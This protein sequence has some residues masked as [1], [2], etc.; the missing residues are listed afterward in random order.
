MPPLPRIR[1]EALSQLAEGFRGRGR[2]V[3]LEHIGRAEALAGEV[4]ARLEYPA[5]WVIFRITGER[6]EMDAPALVSGASLLS[7]LSAIVERLCEAAGL[8]DH[9]VAEET[10]GADELAQRWNIS[11]K[12]IDRWRRQGLVARRV[13]DAQN[14][15]HV[16]FSRMASEAFAARRPDL[17]DRAGGF[18]RID[19]GTRGEMLRRAA[20]YHDAL[21]CSLS[22]SA[23]RLARRF[24]RSHEAIR[25]L[26]MR[27]EAERVL[28]GEARIFDDPPPLSDRAQRAIERGW[29]RG[30]EPAVLMKRYRRSRAGIH[31]IVGEQR[32]RRLRALDLGRITPE[33]ATL[34]ERALEEVL[35]APPVLAL[36]PASAPRDTRELV[37]FMRIRVVP[38]AVEERARAR[39][40]QALRA[41]ALR[42]VGEL[43]STFP[44]ASLLDRAETDLRW[45]A[46]LRALLA[47]THL[48]LIVETLESSLGVDLG[49]MRS[50]EAVDLIGAGLIAARSSLDA[51]D[52]WKAGRLAAGIGLAVNRAGAA[53]QRRREP[54]AADRRRAQV[55]LASGSRAPD[56][57]QLISPWRIAVDPDP[58]FAGICA[59]L[60]GSPG[61]HGAFLRARFGLGGEPPRTLAE[62]AAAAG[63]TI[64]QAGRRERSA[65]RAALAAARAG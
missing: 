10:E 46:A 47:R 60:E 25:Q 48:R 23:E 38:V 22:Q 50:A 44:E 12:T 43:S 17:L 52:P 57:T 7:D 32:A 6:P 1:T 9:E 35:T 39:A 24:D 42:T 37:E 33:A 58:R 16:V 54:E 34:S 27:H 5:D 31:R 14:Q 40:E 19:E 53:L 3:L 56:W 18:S 15:A 4:E 45:A 49:M 30:I 29:R 21:G 51:F 13:R 61:G 41:R 63:Q 8:R 65:V 26:L 64:M 62:V 28:R 36:E 11:R 2:G 55:L 20:R 59:L